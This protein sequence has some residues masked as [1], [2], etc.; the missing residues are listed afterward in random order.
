[1]GGGQITC[2]SAIYRRVS[3]YF[4]PPPYVF[5]IIRLMTVTTATVAPLIWDH[6]SSP[7]E[8][9][10]MAAEYFGLESKVDQTYKLATELDVPF[11]QLK[12]RLILAVEEHGQPHATKG[13]ILHGIKSELVATFGM[14]TSI[15]SAAVKNFRLALQSAG[16]TRILGKIFEERIT[17]TLRPQAAGILRREQMSEHLSALFARCSVTK[18]RAPTLQVRER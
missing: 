2:L 9:D 16:R 13:R 3:I 1:V 11:E 14:S 12:E 7:A 4:F 8:I 15:D 17:F 10:E 6:C 18:Q 5:A